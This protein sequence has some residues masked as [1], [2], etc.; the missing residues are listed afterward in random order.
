MEAPSPPS[1]RP[2][3]PP[4]PPPP[5]PPD[6]RFA[7]NPSSPDTEADQTA[8]LYHLVPYTLPYSSSSGHALS[9]SDY[10]FF[11]PA[12]ASTC[13]VLAPT[14]HGGFLSYSNEVSVRL[15]VGEFKL[16]VREE[17]DGSAP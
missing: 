8:Y 16:C 14:T 4:S 13:P 6:I 15:H 11:I 12:A 10:V 17:L 2:P 3:A 7:I 5:P 9:P 1:R